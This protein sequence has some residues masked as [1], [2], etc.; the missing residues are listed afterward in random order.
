[1]TVSQSVLLDANILVG[2]VNLACFIPSYQAHHKRGTV[3]VLEVKTIPI[4]IFGCYLGLQSFCNAN[5]MWIS[6]FWGI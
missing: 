3:L 1:M 5:D 2:E 6:P 4:L